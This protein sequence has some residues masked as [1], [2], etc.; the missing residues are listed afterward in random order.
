M[1]EV[2]QVAQHLH[3]IGA[4]PVLRRHQ[5]Q[6][7][8]DGAPQQGVGEVVGDGAIGQA[9]HPPDGLVVDAAAGMGNCLIEQ[10]QRVADAAVGGA[11][12]QMQGGRV[13]AGALAAGDVGEV[14]G[15][16]LLVDAAQVEALAARQHRDRHLADLG[17]GEDEADVLGRL[18][19]RLQQA[20]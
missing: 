6:R 9:Q 5:R 16:P 4:G 1:G 15:Q 20:R 7:L 8:G 11:G 19:Q 12:E 13:D 10:R 2:E 3:R 17:G 14:L 18:L